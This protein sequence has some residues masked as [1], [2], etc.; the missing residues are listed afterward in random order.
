MRVHALGQLAQGQVPDGVAVNVI[1]GLK[2]VDV[3]Q[4][5]HAVGLGVFGQIGLQGLVKA[6]AVE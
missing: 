2:V 5:A 1:D 6:L 4:H 3:Q